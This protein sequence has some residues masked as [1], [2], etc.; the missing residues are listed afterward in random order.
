MRTIMSK[1]EPLSSSFTIVDNPIVAA[2][3]HDDWKI[4][5]TIRQEPGSFV[6]RFFMAG[7]ISKEHPT[8]AMII[9]TRFDVTRPEFNEDEAKQQSFSYWHLR[10]SIACKELMG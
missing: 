4:Q 9:E 1:L 3:V 5:T 10:A 2:M 6:R 7:C 8:V